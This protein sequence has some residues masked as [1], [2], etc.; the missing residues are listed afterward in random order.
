MNITYKVL[1]V[2]SDSKDKDNFF[3]W[4]LLNKLYRNHEAEPSLKEDYKSW[5]KA[6]FEKRI[7]SK[8]ITAVIAFNGN[9][10]IGMVLC[11]NSVYK[12]KI[13]F[14]SC[15]GSRKKP[16]KTFPDVE[17]ICMGFTAFYVKNEY[18]KNGIGTN[19]IKTLEK[20]KYKVLIANKEKQTSLMFFEARQQANPLI[21]KASKYSYPVYA[22]YQNHFDIYGTMLFEK[23]LDTKLSNYEIKYK[24][25]AD[26]SDIEKYNLKKITMKT[27]MKKGF[28]LIDE[29]INKRI[30]YE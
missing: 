29:K 26:I 6:V 10:P 17:A 14:Y 1:N 19:L 4:A 24:E 27:L 21:L 12:R 22:E 3:K 23:V 25:E 20:E 15:N 30:R 18:R 8:D 28:P 16:Y 13:D 9:E 5:M 7:D 11:K 2:L